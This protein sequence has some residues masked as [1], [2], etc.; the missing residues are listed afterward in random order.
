MIFFKR[1]GDRL[2]EGDWGRG[3]FG[4]VVWQ[5]EARLWVLGGMSQRGLVA[6]APAVGYWT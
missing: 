6:E 2:P 4:E 5:T 3:L 1:K